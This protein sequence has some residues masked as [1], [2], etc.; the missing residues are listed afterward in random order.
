MHNTNLDCGLVVYNLR[1]YWDGHELLDTLSDQN[2]WNRIKDISKEKNVDITF[3]SIQVML[4][5]ALT[6][7]LT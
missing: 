7:L 4:G 5:L 6:S 2:V 1:I 3:E